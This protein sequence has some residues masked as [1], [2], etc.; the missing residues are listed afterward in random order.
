LFL[1]IPPFSA[2]I[3]RAAL[4]G[5]VEIAKMPTTIKLIEPLSR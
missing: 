4:R 1:V 2:G 5:N 3:S